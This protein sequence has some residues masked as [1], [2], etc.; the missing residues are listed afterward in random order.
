MTYSQ[1]YH[2]YLTLYKRKIAEKTQESYARIETLIE[3][4]IGDKVLEAISP[5][6][7]QAALVCVEE[8]AGSRQAQIA[9]ALLHA[10][11]GRAVKSQHLEKSPVDFIDK[12]EHEAE[13]GQALEGEDWKTLEPIIS[14]NVAYSLM[15]FAGL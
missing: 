5:D 9:Y 3:P 15:C 2:N 12:P 1:W 7:I 10:A 8:T 4:I 11:F 6:D 13:T 14:A